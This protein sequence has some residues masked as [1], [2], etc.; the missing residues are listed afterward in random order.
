MRPDIAARLFDAA[1]GDFAQ[2]E[3]VTGVT[4]VTVLSGYT[5]KGPALH[6]L[7]RLH[8]ENG[9]L[10]KRVSEGVTEGVTAPPEPA[11]PEPDALS[12]HLPGRPVGASLDAARASVAL[13]IFNAEALQREADRRNWEAAEAR[14]TDRYC[15]CG[16]L[17]TVAVGRFKRS[18]GN[19]EGVA[20]W[21]CI[22]CFDAGAT[23]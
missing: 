22:E 23:P 12:I 4:G 16:T 11:H 21:L 19:P 7:H 10:G 3:G 2:K 20:R 8:L 14:L 13:P 9:G 5:S 1:T 18:P 17:A 6:R 15:A